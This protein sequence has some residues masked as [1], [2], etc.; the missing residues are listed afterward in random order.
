MRCEK[1]VV[2]AAAGIL[3]AVSQGPA[4]AVEYPY[5]LTYV[6]GWSGT[7]ERCE[8]T[9]MQQCQASGS[10]LNGS[11]APNWRLGFKNESAE[12][13]DRSPVTGKRSRR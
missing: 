9:T 7:I 2:L 6:E 1:W 11:C 5:C 8:Y 3:L 4:H 13:P 12:T 10:G